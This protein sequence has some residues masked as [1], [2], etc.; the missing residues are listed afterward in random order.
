M[1]QMVKYEIKKILSKTGGKIALSLVL[2][3]VIVVS[4]FAIRSV[5]FVGTDGNS[6]YGVRAAKELR[7]L[8]SAWTGYLTEDVFAEVI[9]LNAEV[10]KTPEAQSK[11]PQESNKANARKQ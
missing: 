11:D 4:V 9:R 2:L 1:T 10:E 7:S 8:K 3:M 5:D 6:I